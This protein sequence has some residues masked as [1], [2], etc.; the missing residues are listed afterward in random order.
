MKIIA[1]YPGRFQPFG[2][3]H[4]ESF[5]WLQSQFGANNSYIVT[6]NIVSLPKSPLNFKD[7]KDIITQY[8]L[9]KH[10]V[11]VKYPYK[12]EELL[13]K[14]DPAT[15]AVVFMVGQKDME[16]D[17]R[18]K[19][20]KSKSGKN[21]YFQ[22]YSKNKNKLKGFD[23][24]GYLVVAPHISI[25][26]PGFGEMSGTAIRNAI[27]SANT[28]I[29][30]KEIF[31]VVFGWYN[32]SLAKKL[33]DKFNMKVE[34]YMS[35]NNKF[36]EEGCMSTKQQKNHNAKVNK[37]KDFLDKNHGREFVYNFDEFPKTVFG[38]K[39]EEKVFWDNFFNLVMEGGAG[40]HMAHPF[41][42]PSVSTGNDLINVFNQSIEYLGK[43][44]ASVKI[45][46]VN[47]S[48]RLVKLNNKLQFVMDRGS[49]KPLD[50]KGI[51]KAE[52]EDRFGAGHGM[53]KVGGTV[54]DIFNDSLPTCKP[55][56]EALGLL[57]NPNIMFNI[58]YVAGS[59]NVLSYGK[60]FLAIH[61]LLEIKQVTEKKRA[62]SEISYNKST[63][64][65]LLNKLNP[66]A[67]NYGYEV[68][69]S[70][71]TT[72]EAQPDLNSELNKKY[73]VN[74]GTKKE[75]KTLKQW[76]A[77]AKVPRGNIKT[78]D[79]KSITA[80]SKEVLLKISEGT[81]L[82]KFIAD[83]KDYQDAID[84]FVIYIATMKLGDAVLE[85]LNSPLGPV[86]EQE[87]IVIRDPKIYNKPFKITGSF[88]IKGMSSSFK[89]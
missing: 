55:E 43:K 3:H 45:D 9:G 12:A 89:K 39:I 65:K 76:L 77:S 72:L 57:D 64:Q 78:V 7:K 44:P 84:G 86:S 34:S 14:F 73:T 24:Y 85:K 25:N 75:T 28:E 49:N 11:N 81:P 22:D 48:I 21:S 23:T 38:V 33:H 36:V 80:L 59:T 88:I 20:G 50:V 67:Q 35:F 19:V 8:G 63:M 71:P 68:L 60:N 47:A 53:I 2:K 51:T 61:G 30:R 58:E 1:I 41:D 5:K 6:S 37:L 79:G 15:T 42:I 10:V 87:G 70:I 66:I 26:I 46:G 32:S 56:L 17:P 74:Y 27:G 16:E 40:G 82:N 62:T 31:P 69:G 52:L 18:F 29:K 13:S 54:L 4:A 83:T